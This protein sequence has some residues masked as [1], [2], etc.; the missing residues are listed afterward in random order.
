MARAKSRGLVKDWA[1]FTGHSVNILTWIT[2]LGAAYLAQGSPWS[3]LLVL[4]LAYCHMGFYA[5]VHDYTHSS[6]FRRA[7]HNRLAA[8]LIEIPSFI[9]FHQFKTTHL[10]HHQTSNEWNADPVSV[11]KND[12]GEFFN[13]L[14]YI[15]YWPFMAQR[16]YTNWMSQQEN[17][18]ELFRKFYL[19]QLATVAVFAVGAA[20]GQLTFMATFWLLPAFLGIV[21]GI[22]LMNIHD[23]WACEPHNQWRDSRTTGSRLFNYMFWHNGLHL[24]HHLNPTA[25][26]DDLWKMHVDNQPVYAQERAVVSRF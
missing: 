4:P 21:V 16:W 14:Y 3:W 2:L 12:K 11:I 17:K 15:V 19:R 5:T 10:V 7:K 20:L 22:G 8:K 13:P 9:Y 26:F 1:K 18:A 25:G 6:P 23:H 24:E